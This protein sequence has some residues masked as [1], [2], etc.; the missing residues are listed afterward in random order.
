MPNDPPRWFTEAMA[1]PLQR[2]TLRVADCA[3]N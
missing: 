1:L 3:I 2:R